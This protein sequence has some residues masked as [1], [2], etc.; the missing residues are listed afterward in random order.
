V[1]AE[2]SV[3]NLTTGH[4]PETAVSTPEPPKNEK[5]TVVTFFKVM[6]KH[7]TEEIE[8]NCKMSVSITD[9]QVEIQIQIQRTS[10]T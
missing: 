8:N 2:L 7:S 10:S 1:L 5:D 6:C 4:Y 3:Q 9:K